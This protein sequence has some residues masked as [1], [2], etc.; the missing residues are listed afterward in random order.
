MRTLKIVFLALG[1]VLL[2]VLLYRVG[3]DPILETL[4]RLTWWQLVLVCLPYAA[5]MAVDTLGWRFAFARD[6]APFWRLLG[7]RLA[8][9]ALNVV[10]A[11]GAVGGEAAK[12]W[13]VRRDVTYEESVPSIIIAK[14]TITMAQAL[15]LLIGLLVAWLALPLT[16]DLLG[17]ML[18]LLVIE[19]A[20][21]G[22]FFGFQVSGLV[23]RGG[24]LL[25]LVGVIDD[26]AHAEML[27]RTLRDYYRTRWRRLVLSLGFHLL[28]WLLGALEA[29]VML[30]A[31]DVKTSLATATAIEALGSGVRFATFLVPASLGPFEAANAAIFAALGFG[32]GAGLAFSLVRRA[33]QV[34]WIAIGI[35]V[36]VLMRWS[37]ARTPADVVAR[38]S[39]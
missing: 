21:V 36:L 27:D 5:V 14:T 19:V 16:S 29:L 35:V 34:V 37:G 24:R 11:V 28:G 17:G 3:T 18:W 4:R 39:R 38:A 2:G 32:V 30:W 33:R 9:E 1:V 20:A 13:L 23:A 22:G 7:A 26:T 8:G 12:A 31:L 15:F 6:R 10:T 25:E